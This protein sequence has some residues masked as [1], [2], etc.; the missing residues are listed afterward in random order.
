MKNRLLG[1]L[2]FILLLFS[3]CSY[4]ECQPPLDYWEKCE[5]NPKICQPSDYVP[6]KGKI[7]MIKKVKTI[8][9]KNND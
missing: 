3:G 6:L 4:N 9:V 8:K 1:L 7:F 5:C 2:M